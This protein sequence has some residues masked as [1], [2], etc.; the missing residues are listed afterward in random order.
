MIWDNL[1]NVFLYLKCIS[2]KRKSYFF[3]SPSTLSTSCSS[4][5]D[6]FKW[7]QISFNNKTRKLNFKYNTFMYCLLWM[8]GLGNGLIKWLQCHNENCH[9]NVL[10]V[11]KK[12]DKS[13]NWILIPEL[14]RF[15]LITDKVSTYYHIMCII[16]VDMYISK[17]SICV[18]QVGVL[19]RKKVFISLIL[20][21]N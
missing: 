21:L 5:E 17:C 14:W 16:S 8:K 2:I 19:Y 3:R 13:K 15:F 4:C 20:V 18:F 1:L 11:S 6:D 12:I 7:F 10:I 9:W